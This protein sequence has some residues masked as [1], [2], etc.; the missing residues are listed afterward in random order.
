MAPRVD[1]HEARA[2]QDDENGKK[3]ARRDE[4]T[5]EAERV[6]EDG[7]ENRSDSDRCEPEHLDHAE[8]AREDLV[9]N[10]AL[11]E[12]ESG[13]V[14]ERVSDPEQREENEGSGEGLPE[15]QHDQRES[16]EDDAEHERG[17]QT[18]RTGERER[19]DA[20]GEGAEPDGRIEVA[21]ALLPEIQELDGGH[22]EKHLDGAR[23]EC[24]CGEQPDEDAQ[25]RI[26]CDRSE[27]DERFGHDR[28][29][30][31]LAPRLGL[32]R[33][34]AEHEER[35]DEDEDCG[36]CE[37]GGSAGDHQQE[38]RERRSC[39]RRETLEGA[40]DRVRSGQL[41]RRPCERRR[42]RGDRGPDGRVRDRRRDR[43]CV[44]DHRRSVDEDAD[45][46]D[47]DEAD[48]KQIGNEENALSGVAVG[49]QTGE[50]RDQRSRYQSKQEEKS[51]SRFSADVVRVHG[52]SDQVRPVA[53]DRRRPCKL[54][55]AEARVREYALERRRRLTDPAAHAR[56]IS[57]TVAELKRRREDFSR[58]TGLV[59]RVLGNRAH[60]QG[61]E[62]VGRD[63]PHG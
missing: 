35:R 27:P 24:L 63:D 20:A 57:P 30:L 4:C 43:E 52:H 41:R 10:G 54:Q 62:H 3:D 16:P 5:F 17:T 42:E 2:E 19:E 32:R 40:R 26:A 37:D 29:R 36:C 25:R 22:D 23:H 1:L 53:D 11:D 55:A 46:C 45:R 49:E 18:L 33:V 34:D 14:D 31:Q 58:D 7:R 48:A 61:G 44:H 9:G 28:A 50:R 47:R 21:D 8:D 39:E 6:D 12:G 13:D 60:R 51:D 56:S 38:S 15:A 59:C